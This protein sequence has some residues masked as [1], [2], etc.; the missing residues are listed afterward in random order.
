[1][2]RLR[3]DLKGAALLL[4]W[5]I[6]TLVAIGVFTSTA[7][8]PPSAPHLL[9]PDAIS[10]SAWGLAAAAALVAAYWQPARGIAL[11]LLS[12]MP[13]VRIA[14][15]T[16]AWV[17]SLIPGPPEGYANGWYSAAIH[18]ALLGLVVVTAAIRQPPSL[19][20]MRN[21]MRELP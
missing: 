10:A 15:Y 16:W 7:T 12:I 21:D 3:P 2:S 4:C 14:S 20:R 6:W 1:M 13:T 8:K 18:M 5:Y 17:V 19:T 11:V 9:I